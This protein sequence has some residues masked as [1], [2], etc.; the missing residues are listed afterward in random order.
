MA[1]IDAKPAPGAPFCREN[2]PIT[3][4]RLY[5]QYGKDARGLKFAYCIAN[6]RAGDEDGAQ[7]GETQRVFVMEAGSLDEA[8]MHARRQGMRMIERYTLDIHR[9]VTVEFVNAMDEEG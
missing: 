8:C 4:I 1:D 7:L 2:E 3:E 6:E 9:T 5:T